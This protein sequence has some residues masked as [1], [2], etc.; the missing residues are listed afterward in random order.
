MLL[1]LFQSLKAMS[2]KETIRFDILDSI[3]SKLLIIF[4]A[5]HFWS[6]WIKSHVSE[7]N[8]SKEK[9][10]QANGHCGQVHTHGD[11]PKSDIS[12][13][14]WFPEGQGGLYFGLWLHIRVL[15]YSY[16][17]NKVTFTVKTFWGLVIKVALFFQFSQIYVL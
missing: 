8:R 4:C 9:I 13:S 12:T 3:V 6:I 5:L 10:P 1:N 7:V 2:G 17:R 14:E 16:W 15:A 11:Y